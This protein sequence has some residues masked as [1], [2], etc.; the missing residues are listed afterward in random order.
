MRLT[1]P[2]GAGSVAALCP[3]LLATAGAKRGRIYFVALWA[4]E[5]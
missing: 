4:R 2:S 3:A 1:Q 5:K